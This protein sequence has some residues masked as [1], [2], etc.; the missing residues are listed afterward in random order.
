MTY[1]ALDPVGDQFNI[2]T[3]LRKTSWYKN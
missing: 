1:F 2:P 3:F